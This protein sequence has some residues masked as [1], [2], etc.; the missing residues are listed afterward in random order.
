MKNRDLKRLKKFTKRMGKHGCETHIIIRP[1]GVYDLRVVSIGSSFRFIGRSTKLN[2]LLK[3]GER[4]LNDY[5]EVKKRLSS[6]FSVNRN[7]VKSK[8]SI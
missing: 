3:D 5:I 7:R 6:F 4:A 8:N 2:K 1:G